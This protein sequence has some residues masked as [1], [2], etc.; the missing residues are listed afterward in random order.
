MATTADRPVRK[1]LPH[2]IPSWVSDGA[3]Y[4]VTINCRVRN[5]NQLCRDGIGA[6]LVRSAEVYAS[7]GRWYLWLLT[8]MPDHVHLIASFDR[9]L[10]IRRIVKAWKGYQARRFGIEWQEGFFEH[11]LR[12]E[13]EF[14]EKAEYIRQNPV[15]KGLVAKAADW[16][17]TWERSR[18]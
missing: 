14:G 17:F 3:R 16:P 10:G 1:K 13:A 9:D 5:V 12:T 18:E 11:R 2:D 8:V 7:Q 6:E 15:R 4:F